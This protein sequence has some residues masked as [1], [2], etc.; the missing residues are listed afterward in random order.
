MRKLSFLLLISLAVGC[1]KEKDVLPWQVRTFV[2][3]W[4]QTAYE[5]KNSVWVDMP[6]TGKPSLIV[7]SDGVLLY[8][9]GLALCCPPE[10]LIVNGVRFKVKPT[11][12]IPYNELCNRIDCISCKVSKFQVNKDEMIGSGCG[13]RTRY[14]R[15]P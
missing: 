10:K 11:S 3:K 9:D 8:G 12:P 4:E 14:R 5:N 15:L 7:R 6:T 2:G 13:N 1:R